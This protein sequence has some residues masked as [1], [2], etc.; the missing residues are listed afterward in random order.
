[1]RRGTALRFDGIENRSRIGWRRQAAGAA[2]PRGLECV[3]AC[4]DSSGGAAAGES[5]ASGGGRCRLHVTRSFG[6]CHRQGPAVVRR[7][8]GWL[9]VSSCTFSLWAAVQA[10]RLVAPAVVATVAAA[11]VIAHVFAPVAPVA[12]RRQG[13]VIVRRIR[14]AAAADQRR[15]WLTCKR[16]RR[17]SL[18]HVHRV[19][20]V[21][22][23]PSTAAILLA[24]T[25]VRPI[26]H[27]RKP[28]PARGTPPPQ[29][30]HA[31]ATFVTVAHLVVILV[32][33]LRT[34]RR[35]VVNNCIVTVL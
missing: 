6:C 14:A 1:M 17:R 2:R 23:Q 28:L 31:R 7:A 33:R 20:S 25:L 9:S 24:V 22:V 10:V 3:V 29:L 4:R 21:A 8:R 16:R 30:A 34:R 19:R 35:L 12:A 27:S 26:V 11:L 5:N 13:R 32:V 15:R 18:V